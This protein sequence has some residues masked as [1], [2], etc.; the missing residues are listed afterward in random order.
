MN[1]WVRKYVFFYFYF[2]KSQSYKPA[3]KTEGEKSRGAFQY[4]TSNHKASYSV[5]HGEL[6][7]KLKKK[8]HDKS[9]SHSGQFSMNSETVVT[10]FVSKLQQ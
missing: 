3:D 7:L 8:I 1:N 4:K 6:K 5:V 2:K 10:C 9:L